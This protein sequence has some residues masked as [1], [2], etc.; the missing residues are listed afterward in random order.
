VRASNV[1]LF[2]PHHAADARSH[3]QMEDNRDVSRSP[4]LRD[5]T[6]HQS[7]DP[8]GEPC[9]QYRRSLHSRSSQLARIGRNVPCRPP[10]ATHPRVVRPRVALRCSSPHTTRTSRCSSRDHRRRLVNRCDPSAASSGC[11]SSRTMEPTAAEAIFPAREPRRRRR[12]APTRRTRATTPAPT[13]PGTRRGELTAPPVRAVRVRCWFT[14]DVSS[15]G[16]S[17]RRCRATTCAEH[18]ATLLSVPARLPTTLPRRDETAFGG[19]WRS[20]REPGSSSR[21]PITPR[22]AS[23]RRRHA[24]VRACGSAPNLAT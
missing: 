23:T 13:C 19:S 6:S 1:Q 3:P 17:R 15:G 4:H 18:A 16:T 2:A 14:V 8:C 5:G 20:G 11:A 22:R 10:V 9:R 21:R 12:R 24:A 7:T